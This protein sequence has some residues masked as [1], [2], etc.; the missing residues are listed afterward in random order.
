M[1]S[2]RYRKNAGGTLTREEP[3]IIEPEEVPDATAGGQGFLSNQNNNQNNTLRF[4][5]TQNNTTTGFNTAK[6]TGLA[7]TTP[8]GTDLNTGIFGDTYSATQ[9]DVDAGLATNVGEQLGNTISLPNAEG[10]LLKE[11]LSDAD[12]SAD[13]KLG[14]VDDK[15]ANLTGMLDVVESDKLNTFDDKFTNIQ[16]ASSTLTEND[17]AFYDEQLS[18]AQTASDTIFNS[19]E[20]NLTRKNDATNVIRDANVNV[21][22]ETLSDAE[23]ATGTM[24]DAAG[25]QFNKVEDAS[26]AL[27][28]AQSDAN[29][30]KYRNITDALRADRL[31][32]MR[33]GESGTVGSSDRMMLEAEMRAADQYANLESA[34]G[35]AQAE[36]TL[37]N[38]Q[39]LGQQETDATQILAEAQAST[40]VSQ[41]DLEAAKQTLS[42]INSTEAERSQ[43][44]S[45]LA[46]AQ[47]TNQT[48][49]ADVDE[50]QRTLQN[51]QVK[52][53]EKGA[54]KVETATNMFKQMN[55]RENERLTIANEIANVVGSTQEETLPAVKLAEL[56]IEQAV[57]EGNMEITTA[58][59]KYQAKIEKTKELLANPSLMEVLSEQLGNE[60]IA[61][62]GEYTAE[63]QIM[64]NRIN[65]L[66][67]IPAFYNQ[68][69][70]SVGPEMFAAY[71]AALG[72]F[73]AIY[74]IG[75]NMGLVD[76]DGLPIIPSNQFGM[77]NT[78]ESEINAAG[79]AI[80]EGSAA[81]S[82]NEGP[83]DVS[84]NKD[85]LTVGVN[86]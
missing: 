38:T 6:T 70:Q 73:G 77:T 50:A 28:D 61:L 11:T 7:N 53:N 45:I 32:A 81:A 25:S 56:L 41:A 83:I 39:K 67:N 79:D 20:N 43:A 13:I 51:T 57:D 33:R 35:L 46:Q 14:A 30:L 82:D 62:D 64:V 72:E 76:A 63:Q 19:A 23:T 4:D 52:E 71:E 78:P 31:S 21:L 54:A 22:N 26:Q 85:G 75:V 34:S 2:P 58:E 65:N 8:T 60:A 1:A 3:K 12:K 10:D 24:K 9:A 55:E 15:F 80:G 17:K 5:N 42:N 37:Q 29:R 49:K 74:Q 36:R 66:K 40:Q 27:A 59:E 86:L 69:V 18:D 47:A 68:I 44:K 16:D 84:L 48:S